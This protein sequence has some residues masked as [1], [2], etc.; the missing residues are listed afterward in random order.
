MSKGSMNSQQGASVCMEFRGVVSCVLTQG[1]LVSEDVVA[2][3]ETL[4]RVLRRRSLSSEV[5][6][7]THDRSHSQATWFCKTVY[8]VLS[9]GKLRQR[10]ELCIRCRILML[11]CAHPMPPLFFWSRHRGLGT[12]IQVPAYLRLLWALCLQALGGSLL[13]LPAAGDLLAA[14]GVPGLVDASP[15]SAS[16]VTQSSSL[17]MCIQ[18][19]TFF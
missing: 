4:G 3:S 19:S 5:D 9:C 10:E 7:R 16:V 12:P 8:L 6:T 11:V 18:I 13:P 1:P 17:C 15:M 14:L 2:S